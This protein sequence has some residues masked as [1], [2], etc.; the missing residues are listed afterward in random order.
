[1]DQASVC[2][3]VFVDL[4]ASPA[5]AG[6]APREGKGEVSGVTDLCM[7]QERAGGWMTAASAHTWDVISAWGGLAAHHR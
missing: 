6:F 4:P 1:M 7:V 5:A 3:G 2:T